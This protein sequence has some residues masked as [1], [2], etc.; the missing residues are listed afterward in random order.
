MT[1]N[2]IKLPERLY[3]PLHEAAEKI[4]CSIKDVIHYGAIGALDFYVFID[5]FRAPNDGYFHLNMPNHYADNIDK[6]FGILSDVGWSI[7][8]LEYKSENDNFSPSG[9]YGKSLHGFFHIWDMSLTGLEF[10]EAVNL[11]LVSI[12]SGPETETYLPVDVN[13]FGYHI[14]LSRDFICILR[15]DIDKFIN[16]D[17]R[18][19][20]D[21]TIAKKAELI[22]ALLKMVP[23]LSSINFDTASVSKI[24]ELIEVIAAKKGVS[25]PE[26]HRQ[27]WQKYLGRR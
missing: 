12:S 8:G 27:T 15:S 13:F 21:K 10:N 17:S 1:N 19:E 25:L 14:D 23:E 7:Y 5:N 26:T 6:N 4:G 24:V 9:Y 2:K 22:P 16:E 11:N 20:S 3:F 18:P